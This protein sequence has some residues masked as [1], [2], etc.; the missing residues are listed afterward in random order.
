MGR[1]GWSCL[2][3][4]GRS[5]GGD[6]KLIPG[7]GSGILTSVYLWGSLLSFFQSGVQ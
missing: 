5:A 2:E 7:V 3:T 1:T 4:L 6:G